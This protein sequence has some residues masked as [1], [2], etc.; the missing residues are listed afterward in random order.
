MLISKW[1][2][3]NFTSTEVTLASYSYLSKDLFQLF[4]GFGGTDNLGNLDA[5]NDDEKYKN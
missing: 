5:L 1:S 4:E 3:Q 2:T